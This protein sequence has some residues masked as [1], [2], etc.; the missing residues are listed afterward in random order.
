MIDEAAYIAREYNDR[1]CSGQ[2]I[3][4]GGQKGAGEDGRKEQDSTE[5]EDSAIPGR[6]EM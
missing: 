4:R 3:N 1:G 5:F 6:E 2:C